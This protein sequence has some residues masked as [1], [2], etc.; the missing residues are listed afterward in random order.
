MTA[1]IMAGGKG[2]RLTALTKDE[3]PKPMMPVRGK[4]LLLRQVETLKQNGVNDFIIIVGHLGNVIKDYFGDGTSLGVNISYITE[5]CPLGSA[6]ALYYLKD[7]LRGDF[8]LV[9]GDTVF[10][11]DVEKMLAFHREKRAV[12]TLFAHPN[13]HPYDSDL[14]ECDKDGRVLAIVGKND[15]PEFYHNLVNAAFFVLNREAL[16]VITSPEKLGLEKDVLSVLI[17]K[18][19]AVYC[20]RSTEYIKDAGTVD[21]IE[22]VSADIESG[23]VSA[24]N[25]KNKQKAVF[26][27]R[28][29]TINVHI[30]FI[31]DHNQVQL[32]DGAAGGIRK[33][34]EAGY[35]TF[36][37]TNQPVIARGE[38][39]F[40]EL[41]IIHRVLEMKLGEAGAY[42]D[43]L[44]F[45]PHHPHKGYPGEIAEL[46]ID[47]ECRKPKTGMIDKLAAKYNVDI[48]E[49]WLVGD[50]TIDIQTAKNAGLKSIMVLTGM[51]GSDNKYDAKPDYVC[52]DLRQAAQLILEK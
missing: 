31:N 2:T 24:R 28:D 3:I 39:T 27:D 19:K 6:G 52:A 40:E 7:K 37:V 23:V 20:Y 10:D 8:L 5:T 49:S 46:K 11:I 25:L 47:C 51:G 26:L 9:F 4:P 44:E 22:A 18:G 50:T 1:V 45:C 29:G 35:L 38:C 14:I 42:I 16:D 33:L 41:D 34:N 36:V 43:D 15:K 12:A 48:S 17:K 32:I 21:R 13:S 30:P